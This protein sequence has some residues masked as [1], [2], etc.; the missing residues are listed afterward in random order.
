MVTLFRPLKPSLLCTGEQICPAAWDGGKQN[1][2]F[3]HLCQHQGQQVAAKV[4]YKTA[5]P[6]QQDS[7]QYFFCDVPYL[8]KTTGNYF[9]NFFAHSQS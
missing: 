6:F 9:C 8:F 4:P 7:K 3:Y 5:N 2:R 1:Q